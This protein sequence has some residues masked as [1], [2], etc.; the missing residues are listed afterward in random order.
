ME[1]DA[2]IY[3]DNAA[4]SY[5]KPEDVYEFMISFYREARREPGAIGLRPLHRGG[6]AGRA[7]TRRLLTP[8]LQRDRPDRLVFGYNS[9][10]ALNLALFGLLQRGDHAITTTIEHNSVLR[11]L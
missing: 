7:D 6:P 8:F 9:T 11:P 2:I 5:P 1:H 3:L 4:T 10:D